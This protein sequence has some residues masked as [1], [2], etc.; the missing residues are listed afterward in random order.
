ML[1]PPFSA[2]PFVAPRYA[3]G[4]IFLMFCSFVRR[5][6]VG[7]L[8]GSSPPEHSLLL[9]LLG[10]GEVQERW[11]AVTHAV[12]KRQ[13]E[14]GEEEWEVSVLVLLTA[15]ETQF[16]RPLWLL[17]SHDPTLVEPKSAWANSRS[18]DLLRDTR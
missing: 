1:V 6:G 14:G 2:L 3:A 4:E 18:M 15:C 8:G 10:H 7:I 16:A 9:N 17:I 5:L 13:P 11:V 12:E